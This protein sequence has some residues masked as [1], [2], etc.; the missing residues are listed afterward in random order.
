MKNIIQW[1]K[2][3]Y[4]ETQNIKDICKIKDIYDDF[5]QSTYFFN[6][7]KHEKQK[8]NKAYFVEY[9]KTNIF[10]K[11]Y[12]VDRYNNYRTILKGWTNKDDNI[13][14]TEHH[15]DED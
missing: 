15:E 3:N 6:L 1:F 8:Y 7:S 10:F 11:K 9:I 5:C 14:D 12:Y 4:E 13:S 2:E